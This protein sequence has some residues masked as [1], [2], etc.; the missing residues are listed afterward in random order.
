MVA[1]SPRC[2]CSA[3]AWVSSMRPPAVVSSSIKCS[4]GAQP[5]ARDK[6][7]KTPLLWAACNGHEDV[8]RTLIG[9]PHNAAEPYIAKGHGSAAGFGT[10]S[11]SSGGK[12]D[13][14]GKDDAF[15]AGAN[16]PLQ[17]AA[18]KGHL[19]IVWMLLKAGLSPYDVDACGNTS[20]HLAATG[21]SSP[22]LKCLMSEGFRSAPREAR[23]PQAFALELRPLAA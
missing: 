2:H 23:R 3:L 19:R 7:G 5:N 22:V 20:L 21:G 17:W 18:F 15:G 11:K 10:D 13:S 1:F 4:L 6:Y 16:T 14:E 12:D 9:A 8:T